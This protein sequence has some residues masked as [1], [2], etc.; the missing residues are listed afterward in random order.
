MNAPWGFATVWSV[1]KRWL[2]PVTVDK[3]SILGANYQPE[4]LAQIP[5]ENL[6]VQFGGMC[7]CPGGCELSDAGP[8]QD[9]QFLSPKQ[10]EK[11][12]QIREAHDRKGHTTAVAAPTEKVEKEGEEEGTEAP[13]LGAA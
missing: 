3:I 2:D 4:L 12:E 7:R 6:P 1:I 10:R 13:A 9:P 8:W 5:A 11:M